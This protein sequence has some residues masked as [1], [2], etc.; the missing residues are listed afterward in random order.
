MMGGELPAVF[1]FI[2]EYGGFSKLWEGDLEVA[3]MREMMGE[4]SW[5]TQADCYVDGY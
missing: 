3:C 5:E 1:M 2:V 4:D